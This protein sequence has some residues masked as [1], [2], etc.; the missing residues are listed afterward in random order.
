MNASQEFQNYCMSLLKKY[1][2][3]TGLPADELVFLTPKYDTTRVT[4]RVNVGKYFLVDLE[5]WEQ[6]TRELEFSTKFKSVTPSGIFHICAYPVEYL[7]EGF[8][9]GEIGVRVGAGGTELDFL[10]LPQVNDQAN[11]QSYVLQVAEGLWRSVGIPT[12]YGAVRMDGENS[13]AY[14]YDPA[15][16]GI[17]SPVQL[18]SE[19][20]RLFYQDLNQCGLGNMP[21][22]WVQ[23]Y[24][25]QAAGITYKK[26]RHVPQY[27]GS[28]QRVIQLEGRKSAGTRLFAE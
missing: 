5:S 1:R 20:Y 7:G 13:T 24:P 10:A 3:S 6:N 28:Y 8:R 12:G 23:R 25:A 9:V 22:V 27:E 18:P 11:L 19:S 15:T 2:D 16:K 14:M 17:S 21:V 4:A 26:L